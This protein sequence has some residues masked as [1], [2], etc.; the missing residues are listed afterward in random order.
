MAEVLTEAKRKELLESYF[1]RRTESASETAQPMA[2]RGPDAAVPLTFAQR[3]LWLHAQLAPD[4]A[5]YNEPITVR[6]HGP[7]EVAALEGAFKEIIRRHEAWRTSFPVVDGEPVQ[8]VHPPFSVDLPEID[9]RRFTAAER[10]AEA[11]R[12]ASDDARLPFDLERGPLFRARL[13]RL[14]DEEHRLYIT[15]HHL[16]FD[17][18]CG[19]RVF[20]PELAALY[21]AFSQG[22]PANLPELPFQFGDYAVAQAGWMEGP[23]VQR[24]LDY[25]R[26]RLAGPLPALDLP[27]SRPLPAAQTF[28]GA[29]QTFSLPLDLST[30]LR[31]LSQREGVT[32]FMTLLAGFKVLLHRYSA[33]D[34]ILVGSNTAGRRYPGSERLLGYFLNTVVLRTDLGGDPT[35]RELLDRVRGTTLDALSHD[36]VP[37]DRLVAELPTGRDSKRNPL[38][39]V[40]FSLE[41]PMAP[42]GPQWDLTCIEVETGATKFELCMVLDDRADGLLCRLIYNTALFD[43]EVIARMGGHWQTLLEAIVADPSRKISELALLTPAERQQL[44][45]EWNNTELPFAPR[46]VHELIVEQ[47]R[48]TPGAIAVQ[49]GKQNLTYRELEKQSEKLA[50]FLQSKG[51]GRGTPVALCFERSVEMIVGILGVLRS[52][53]AYVPLDPTNPRGRLELM[54]AD[55]GAKVL[56]TQPDSEAAGVATRIPVATIAEAL[57]AG[58]DRAQAQPA[59]GLDDLAYILYTSGSTGVP[60]GV[61][62]THRNLACSH[63]ARVSYYTEAPQRFLL[64][65]S[66]AFDSSV[67]GIFHT[68][69]TGGALVI[70][71]R[72]FRW[73]AEQL[74]SLIA[75]N[76]ITH[77]LTFPSLYGELLD[78]VHAAKLASLRLVIVAGESCPRQVVNA[79]YKILPQVPLFNEYGPTEGT[80]WSSVCECEPGGEDSPVPIGRPVAN[81]RLYVVDRHAQPVPAGVPGELYVGGGGVARGYLNQPALTEKSFV[82]DPFS[83]KAESRLYRTG[84]LARHFPDGSIE[85]LGRLDQQVKIRGLRVELEEVEAALGQHPA[86]RD[87]AVV[88][89]GGDSA[90][91]LVAFVANPARQPVSAGEL[92]TFLRMRVP[93]YMVPA[94]FQL[95]DALP[96]TANGKVDRQKLASGEIVPSDATS[97]IILPRNDAEKRLLA[98]WKSVLKTTSDDVTQD[99]FELGGHSLLAAKLLARIEKEFGKQLSLAFVFHCPTVAQM[100]DSLHAAGQSLR[101]RAVIPIQPQGSLS[102]L[103]WVRGGP[104]FR[105]LGQKLGLRR[106]LLGVDLPYAD[107]IRLPIPYRLEDIAAYL[108]RAMRE[109]QPHGPYYL[110]GL[111]V[112]AV[113]AYEMGRQLERQGEA[114]ALVAMLDAHNAAYYKNPFKDGRYTAR[115]K[116]HFSNLLHMN[117]GETSTYLL[118]RLDEARRKIER[119]TWRLTSERGD[120]SDDRFRNTDSIVHPAFARFEPQPYAGK[121][122]LLQSSEWPKSPYF[123]FKLGWDDIAGAIDFYRIPG[124]HAYMFD[125][126]NVNAV[127]ETLSDYLEAAENS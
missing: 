52:G 102:P 99:F 21:N 48:K 7:L 14:E 36:E 115:I 38:F 73:E 68:L 88:V 97:E 64:L 108:I 13:V 44:L 20:L 56:L 71:P 62:I 19:Y 93:T 69:T 22:Q 34:D 84:D 65:S 91:T 123:D 66:Y 122:V 118:D 17:G 96:R 32:L 92:R 43:P 25:W 4:T 3:Q 26:S 83:E 63:H 24:S 67:A 11:M 39:Q 100:A 125:E 78:D 72:E 45:V 75:E 80:V 116:Y 47:A 112:N 30:R 49:C 76:R 40:L 51:A 50:R 95:V 10:E 58:G 41:P 114:V 90:A 119:I 6:H 8:Q 77:T 29:M 104:R 120:H 57:R 55:S 9:L 106:P 126:P 16:I 124:D 53:G 27:F 15:L 103:F 86:V 70:P 59:S 109:V 46:P 28:R 33:Q 54:L 79:H 74:A 12:I 107:G 117:A 98:I 110:A 81:T 94:S 31:D 60:K 1:R 35:F 113:I 105:L 111:C 82:R 101:Q 89:K 42:V 18:F 85:F 37:L 121:I 5:L 87:A 127:A 61:Q 2:R 23:E